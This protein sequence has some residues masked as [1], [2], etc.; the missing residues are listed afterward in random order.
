MRV[1]LISIKI[2]IIRR[3]T[4]HIQ[5]EC[6]SRHYLHFVGHHTH[7][8][9][10]RLSIELTPV[11]IHQMSIDDISI[12]QYNT[13]SVNIFQIN[14]LRMCDSIL[15]II[16]LRYLLSTRMNQRTSPNQTVKLFLVIFRNNL[17]N[18]KI[19]R[20]FHRN[21]IF[22]NTNAWI[23]TN[24]SPSRKIHS[25]SHNIG[26]NTTLLS[27]QSLT[28]HFEGL[29]TS[30]ATNWNI[31]NLIINHSRNVPLNYIMDQINLT[32]GT[33]LLDIGIFLQSLLQFLF[34]KIHIL[35]N[36]CDFGS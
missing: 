34:K 8:V 21:T 31:L 35:H 14:M 9:K 1:H 15:V 32:R 7:S 19:H 3:S 5:T 6:L 13:V 16:H 30:T 23:H 36:F 2:R 26:P 22:I 4:I 11:S 33:L 25:F 20:D 24:D 29:S 10:R 27:F 18:R 28:N 17:R 12:L